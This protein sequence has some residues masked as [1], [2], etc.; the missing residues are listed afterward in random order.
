LD[1]TK[2]KSAQQQVDELNA[3]IATAKEALAK[4]LAGG[5]QISLGIGF[6]IKGG[7]DAK[8]EVQG[9]SN[10]SASS[11][12]FHCH[13]R[14]S[15]PLYVLL[16]ILCFAAERVAIEGAVPLFKTAVAAS[17]TLSTYP[18]LELATDYK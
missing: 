3:G 1:T 2:P 14:Y 11:F 17:A 4:F 15:L 10:C 8:L 12:V 13:Y 6:Q 16:P 9:N 18:S 5:P 7:D